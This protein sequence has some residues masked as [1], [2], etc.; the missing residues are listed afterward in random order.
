MKYT[1][2]DAISKLKGRIQD[3]LLFFYWKSRLGRIGKESKIK[4]GVKVVGNA[5][6]I[7]IGNNFKVWHR[8]FVTVGTGNI[9][10]GDNGHLGVDVYINAFRGNITI[11]QAHKHKIFNKNSV[12]N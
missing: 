10:F 1:T 11:E 6:R 5:K 9:V 7:A 2:F 4:G 8:C 12:I 3:T